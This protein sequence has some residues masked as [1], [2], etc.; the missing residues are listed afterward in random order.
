[1][2]QVFF[3]LH[4]RFVRAF[5]KVF[6]PISRGI[7]EKLS[8]MNA[9]ISL[10]LLISL[11]Y[12]FIGPNARINCLSSVLHTVRDSKSIDINSIDVY[13]I[14]F[15]DG[16]SSNRFYLSTNV[17]GQ[18][19]NN[20][21]SI[22][23]KDVDIYT[24][25]NFHYDDPWYK[26]Y[27][28][29]FDMG[30]LMLPYRE[31]QRYN[32]QQLNIEISR[33]TCF[34]SELN[35]WTIKNIIGEDTIMLNWFLSSFNGRGYMYNSHSKEMFNLYYNYESNAP[36][37]SKE[38][39]ANYRGRGTGDNMKVHDGSRSQ[40]KVHIHDFEASPTPSYWQQHVE[41]KF[42]IA[43]K[44]GFI[45]FSTTSL[46][47]YTL[48]ETQN[49]ML[50]FTF[51]LQE[52]V[53]L[54]RPYIGLIAR[55]LLETL[56]FV[57]IFVGF[58]FFLGD[59]FL[60]DQLLAFAVLS[61]VWL[62]EVYSIICVRATISIKYFPQF[63]CCYFTMFHIY[64]LSF[65]FGFSFL[66]LLCTVLF[67]QHAMLYF[68]SRFEVPALFHGHIS[69]LRPRTYLNAHLYSPAQV[70][71]NGA[72]IS[73]GDGRAGSIEGNR[74]RSASDN[75]TITTTS[76]FEM[77][78]KRTLTEGGSGSTSRMKSNGNSRSNSASKLAPRSRNNNKV[79]I[80]EDFMS[81]S[82]YYTRMDCSYDSG[83]RNAGHGNHNL[84]HRYGV[85]TTN[86]KTEYESATPF[87]LH[88]RLGSQ[89]DGEHEEYHQYGM[90]SSGRSLFHGKIPAPKSIKASNESNHDNSHPIHDS[91]EHQS[92]RYLSN[93]NTYKI[94][95]TYP[96]NNTTTKDSDRFQSRQMYQHSGP[97]GN[98]EYTPGDSSRDFS[99]FGVDLG[100]DDDEPTLWG[101]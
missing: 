88:R 89:S 24:C 35:G 92:L 39:I 66:A 56:V 15:V 51:L 42:G 54:H 23:V 53:R 11:H 69:A 70:G 94:N 96:V 75:V 100:S 60:T 17:H 7:L 55:H 91:S 49:R 18:N 27:F 76:S 9:M 93:S 21:K 34:G 90:E 46:V 67:I 62:A 20:C 82:E 61:V 78:R 12:F 98:S 43:A 57:P 68:W 85:R 37:F 72:W 1:M 5:C 86:R 52:Q 31:R 65:P 41:S 58:Q 48:R 73:P 30:Y 25:H 26:H 2:E 44:I 99:V 3:R 63:F 10:V 83:S 95:R 45:Y 64:S 80:R 47:S 22:N 71:V 84:S 28:Y 33:N 8:L 14:R 101:Y 74:R 59:F 79:D 13:D 6:P 77:L 19:G 36:G 29:S 38:S 97:A 81:S 50:K 4:V 87:S 16:S 32:I 40:S